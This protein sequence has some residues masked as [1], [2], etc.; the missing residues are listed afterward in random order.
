MKVLLLFRFFVFCNSTAVT[1]FMGVKSHFGG[2][3][4]PRH[5]AQL[6]LGVLSKIFLNISFKYNIPIEKYTHH[7]LTI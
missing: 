6:H 3:D 2:G 7:A 4:V 5:V 1:N